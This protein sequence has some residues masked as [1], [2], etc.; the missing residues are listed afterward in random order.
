MTAGV[1]VAVEHPDHGLA[2]PIDPSSPDA[3]VMHLR[4]FPGRLQETGDSWVDRPWLRTLGGCRSPSNHH[5]RRWGLI[6]P[7]DDPWS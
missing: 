1:G 6:H 3:G 5:W 7:A 2:E 4:P